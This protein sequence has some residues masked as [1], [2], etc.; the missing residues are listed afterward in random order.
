MEPVLTGRPN[1][2]VRT[3]FDPPMSTRRE[4]ETSRST[5]KLITS[6]I[7]TSQHEGIDYIKKKFDSDVNTFV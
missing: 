7:K 1:D 6:P 5:A 2:R 3:K 4:G